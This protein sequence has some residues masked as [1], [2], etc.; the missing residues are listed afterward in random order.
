MNPS[1]KIGFEFDLEDAYGKRAAEGR[2]LIV[3]WNG[4][5]LWEDVEHEV[6]AGIDG[7]GNPVKAHKAKVKFPPDWKLTATVPIPQQAGNET[8]SPPS[9][10]PSDKVAP[11]KS[12]SSLPSGPADAS[13]PPASTQGTKETDKPVPSPNPWWWAPLAIPALLLAWLGLRTHKQ[14]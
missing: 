2:R 5:Q 7:K 8:I 11:E 14:R 1:D 12:P 9:G 6:P 10:R 3:Y 13:L 4:A